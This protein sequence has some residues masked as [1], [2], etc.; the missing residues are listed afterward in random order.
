VPDRF[1]AAYGCANRLSCRFVDID[2]ED[3]L[4]APRLYALWMQVIAVEGMY[5]GFA[6]AKTGHRSAA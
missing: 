3:P 2:A 5:A 1:A 6:G 4:E